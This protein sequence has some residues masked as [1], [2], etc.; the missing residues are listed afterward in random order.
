M[1]KKMLKREKEGEFFM[2]KN[3]IEEKLRRG[4]FSR[5]KES[6]LAFVNF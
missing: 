6:E 1:H 2:N 4:F 3:D 5:R